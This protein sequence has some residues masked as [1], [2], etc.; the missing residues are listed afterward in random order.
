M[1]MDIQLHRFLSF[2]PKIDALVKGSS[3]VDALVECSWCLGDG[4][5]VESTS[6]RLNTFFTMDF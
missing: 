4:S 1:R 5:S 3:V 2:R 6:V